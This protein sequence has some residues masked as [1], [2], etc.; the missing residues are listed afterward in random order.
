M[1]NFVTAGALGCA[2]LAAIAWGPPQAFA[3]GPGGMAFHAGGMAFHGGHAG[4]AFHSHPAV[5][6]HARPFF[7]HH[8]HPFFRHHHRF[9]NFAFIGFP[10]YDNYNN[11]GYGCGWLYRQAI[12]TGSQYWWYRYYQCS[13]Y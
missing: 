12:Y 1:K 7:A 9:R 3:R 4:M 11:Y 2:L 10:Y 5:F 13:G 6:S 8:A